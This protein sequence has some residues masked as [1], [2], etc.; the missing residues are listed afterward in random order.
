MQY[1]VKF[2]NYNKGETA[3]K[4]FGIKQNV[5]LLSM[6]FSC[7]SRRTK[8][9]IDLPVSRKSGQQVADITQY[10]FTGESGS[11]DYSGQSV[12]PRSVKRREVVIHGLWLFPSSNS[13]IPL[14]FH[15]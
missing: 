12:R 7:G 1:L 9:A 4:G 6:Q 2:F 15:L 11:F 3:L 5:F 14:P 8:S 10:I 13:S